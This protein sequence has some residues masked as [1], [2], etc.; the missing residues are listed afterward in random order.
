MLMRELKY[1]ERTREKQKRGASEE[2]DRG[3]GGDRGKRAREEKWGDR[4]SRELI[5]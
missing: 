2:R 1:R 3:K 5:E 4:R